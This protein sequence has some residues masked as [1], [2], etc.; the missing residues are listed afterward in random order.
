MTTEP[1]LVTEHKIRLLVQ[2]GMKKDPQIADVPLLLDLA[3]TE[4]DR[5]VL[6]AIF[7]KYEMARPLFAGPGVPPARIAELRT[8]FDEAMKDP[9]LLKEAAAQRIE[10]DPV[11]GDAIQKLVDGIYRLPA[12]L[13][14]Q[15]RELIGYKGK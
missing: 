14:G 1:Q 13:V 2:I 11:D 10:L 5:S 6:Q 4:A 3:P 15:V 7:A 9:A 8:A 12:P